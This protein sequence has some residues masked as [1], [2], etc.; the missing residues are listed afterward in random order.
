[1]D[2][3]MQGNQSQLVEVAVTSEAYEAIAYKARH[4]GMSLQG[5]A[6]EL[7]EEAT[8]LRQIMM[9]MTDALDAEEAPELLSAVA[10]YG[11]YWVNEKETADAQMARLREPMAKIAELTKE[12]IGEAFWDVVKGLDW[13]PVDPRVDRE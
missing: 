12:G 9:R 7:L 8:R 5:A 10:D 13:T 1:M 11:Q 6:S 4:E 2:T 3:D